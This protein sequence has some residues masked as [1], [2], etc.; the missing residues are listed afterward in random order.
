VPWHGQRT[1]SRKNL[2]LSH[3]PKP[4]GLGTG[5]V[6]RGFPRRNHYVELPYP[7]RFPAQPARHRGTSL[8]THWTDGQTTI[9]KA[10]VTRSGRGLGVQTSTTLHEVQRPLLTPDECLRMPGPRKD[11]QALITG[12]RRYGGPLRRFPRPSTAGSH[13]ILRTKPFLPGLRFHLQQTANLSLLTPST[14]GKSQKGR[15]YTKDKKE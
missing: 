10:Q 6:D 15:V 3:V 9:I 13:S 12:A 1:N 8:Q 11:A 2:Q 14:L 7:N 4:K 5:T